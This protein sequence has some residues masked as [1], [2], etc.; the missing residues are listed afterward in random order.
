MD[1]VTHCSLQV[2][3]WAW[4]T[5]WYAPHSVLSLGKWVGSQVLKSFFPGGSK[6]KTDFSISI[7]LYIHICILYIY[8]NLVTWLWNLYRVT[9]CTRPKPELRLDSVGAYNI[10]G[11]KDY[12]PARHA[13]DVIFRMLILGHFLDTDHP[14]PPSF[15]WS[16]H[17]WD[18]L[19]ERL[20]SSLQARSNTSFR[21]PSYW[22]K[23]KAGQRRNSPVKS[24]P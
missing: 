24:M 17:F 4:E 5:R 10:G 14:G 16:F 19:E 23:V 13:C 18:G 20:G 3:W 7:Y 8:Y 6:G 9:I 11:C 15:A 12:Q 1:I 22:R 21:L 2:V